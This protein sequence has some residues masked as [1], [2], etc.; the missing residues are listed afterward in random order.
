MS[1]DD[2]RNDILEAEEGSLPSSAATDLAGHSRVIGGILVEQPISG[3]NLP[4]PDYRYTTCTIKDIRYCN[5]DV[6]N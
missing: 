5:I 1:R 4:L 6:F 3:N 2:L